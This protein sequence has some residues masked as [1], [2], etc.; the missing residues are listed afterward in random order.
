MLDPAE[1]P[2]TDLDDISEAARDALDTDNDEIMANLLVVVG[3][4]NPIELVDGKPRWTSAQ[5]KLIIDS[6]DALDGI[7]SAGAALAEPNV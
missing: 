4:L 1:I 5:Q 7:T 3:Q 2:N 6:K